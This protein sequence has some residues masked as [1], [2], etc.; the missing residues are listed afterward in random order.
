VRLPWKPGPYHEAFPQAA[1]TGD[2][3]KA[4][5]EVNEAESSLKSIC[6]RKKNG[7]GQGVAF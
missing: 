4:K 5:A 1:R 7:K 6:L 2:G 3:R